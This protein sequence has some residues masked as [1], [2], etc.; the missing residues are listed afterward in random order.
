MGRISRMI[1]NTHH[2]GL[3]P[4]LIVHRRCSPNRH[5]IR[6]GRAVRP[7]RGVGDRLFRLVRGA[8][9]AGQGGCGQ[10]IAV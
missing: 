9:T 6:E 5:A 7:V 2:R 4:R 1:C 3:T 10:P 8:G